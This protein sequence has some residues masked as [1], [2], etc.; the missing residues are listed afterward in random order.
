MVSNTTIPSHIAD[1]TPQSL[2]TCYCIFNS[3]LQQCAKNENFHENSLFSVF[4]KFAFYAMAEMNADIKI[5]YSFHSRCTILKGTKYYVKSFQVQL[6]V[7]IL[8]LLKIGN[9]AYFTDM[10]EKYLILRNKCFI[11]HYGFNDDNSK[12][13]K[14]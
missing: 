8:F 9:A 13:S 6:F 3:I 7:Y 2:S 12:W 4:V 11:Y 5:A 14:G 10:V 1:K